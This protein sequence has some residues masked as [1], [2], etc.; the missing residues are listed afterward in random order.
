MTRMDRNTRI[1]LLGRFSHPGGYGVA[2]RALFKG[3]RARQLPVIGLDST[4]ASPI[5]DR[6]CED[7]EILR[8]AGQSTFKAKG[9]HTRLVTIALENPEK[10]SGIRVSGK[11]HLAGYTLT[12]TEQ[13]PFGWKQEMLS[14][15]RLL[16]PT[17]F[18]MQA[19]AKSGLPQ[20]LMHVLPLATDTDLFVSEPTIRPFPNANAF[21]F[22]HVVS[23]FN[24][25]DVGSLLRAYFEAFKATDDVTLIIK[26]PPKIENSKFS[27]FITEAISPWYKIDD[28]ALPHVLIIPA[29]LSDE[30]M[31]DLYASCHAYVSLERGKGWDYPAIEAMLTGRPCL[32][33]D[34]GSNT[35]FQNADNSLVIP[36][37]KGTLMASSDLFENLNLY[38][39]HTWASASVGEA[40]KG[41]RDL[42][43]RYP[44][45]RQK[46]E[47][48]RPALV[49]LAHP[50]RV[51]DKVIAYI[52]NLDSYEYRGNQAAQLEYHSNPKPEF[53]RP[54]VRRSPYASLHPEDRKLV[55]AAYHPNED[56]NEWVSRRRKLWGSV[57]PVLPPESE[58]ARLESLR[59]K[60]YGQSIF[61]VGN[62]PSLNKIDLN[63]IGDTASF[64]TNKIY[65]MFDRVK[66]HPNFYT[67]LDWRVTPDNLDQINALRGMTFFF[68]FR[69]HGMLRQGED[70]FWYESLS[71]GRLHEE[72][73]EPNAPQGIRGGG[74]VLTAA[75][76]IAFFLGFTTQYLIGVDVS[77]SIPQTVKQSGGDRFGTGV[78]INL[79]STKDDD[80]N[81][82]DPRYFGK[83][84]K[85]HDPN[86]DEMKRG[87]LQTAR[88]IEMRGGRVFN[89]TAGGNLD[90]VTRMRFED[91][92]A[93]S[94]AER[95]GHG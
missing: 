84:A 4:T 8:E 54:P 86:V 44:E 45:W 62:G 53:K 32:T 57:G 48:A 73:F 63:L 81:H 69:F 34:W 35:E 30:K 77:Y 50:E 85:W 2:T 22:L 33:I 14:V 31:A 61:I 9:A 91:A 72:K 24:R 46:A 42:H 10:W 26:L 5:E 80:I 19:L 89:A 20:D 59:N 94:K 93:A 37:S 6:Y 16:I 65:Y 27:Q 58:R 78:Q 64:A 76:Q 92:V 56:A 11:V 51:A 83:G 66:W 38:T 55:N 75:M 21:R 13:V 74:T 67:T 28:P 47:A 17:H 49:N 40:A 60:Y 12:E 68:P 3:L 52:E 90:C 18:N 23:N 7:F 41:L 36:A 39:G 71:P 95:E 29:A 82:F 25:K 88:G 43:D 70:V 1:I 87:F 15:D 79:E